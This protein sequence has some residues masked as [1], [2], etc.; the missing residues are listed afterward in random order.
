[1]Q[2]LYWIRKLFLALI[3]IVLSCGSLYGY[4]SYLENH[5]LKPYKTRVIYFSN[6][7][8]KIQENP[9]DL[10]RTA[11]VPI[12]YDSYLNYSYRMSELNRDLKVIYQDIL[13]KDIKLS[14]NESSYVGQK[15]MVR[16]SDDTIDIQV[17]SDMASQLTRDEIFAYAT[18][19]L[20]HIYLNHCRTCDRNKIDEIEADLWAVNKGIDP[21]FLVSALQKL[22]S[23]EEE[24][25]DR[26]RMMNVFLVN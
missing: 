14:S 7:Y 18:H 13:N 25:N 3:L 11:D 2:S 4:L 8:V 23:I 9:D 26:I 19:E 12:S 10:S 5:N 15:S 21:K 16:I 1:M 24:R 6:D 17:F 20:A 22:Q